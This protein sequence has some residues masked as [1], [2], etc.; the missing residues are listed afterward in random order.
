MKIKA[1][2]KTDW[3]GPVDLKASWDERVDGGF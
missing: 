2:A 1:I 3:M